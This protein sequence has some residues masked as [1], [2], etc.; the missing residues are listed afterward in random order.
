M[1]LRVSFVVRCEWVKM[2][3]VYSK[4]LKSLNCYYRCCKY[5]L[6]Y[7]F[8]LIDY[9]GCLEKVFEV[10]LGLVGYSVWVY[11]WYVMGRG[12]GGDGI[13]VWFLSFF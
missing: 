12:G 13:C 8:V 11:L 6:F 1:C 10:F 3:K 7:D 9:S 2:Y 4:N 5:G